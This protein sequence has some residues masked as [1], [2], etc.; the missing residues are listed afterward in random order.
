MKK[1]TLIPI[2]VGACLAFGICTNLTGFG[3]S[4]VTASVKDV[5][6]SD[7]NYLES[8][9]SRILPKKDCP[10]EKEVIE[11]SFT[12]ALIPA[13]IS[14]VYPETPKYDH[15]AEDK[16][17]TSP[18][19]D[20]KTTGVSANESQPKVQ[21][22]Q[23]EDVQIADLT[24]VPAEAE[25]AQDVYQEESSK[26]K[27]SGTAAEK[28]VKKESEDISSETKATKATKEKEE[29]TDTSAEKE[30]DL[31]DVHEHVLKPVYKTVHHDA[32]TH[33]ETKFVETGFESS[34]SRSVTYGDTTVSRG[35]YTV[36]RYED[37]SRVIET[38]KVYYYINGEEAGEEEYKAALEKIYAEAEANG[39]SDK[40]EERAVSGICATG[41]E[42][43]TEVVDSE[44]YDEE[45][46]DHY[47]C[48]HC[49]EIVDSI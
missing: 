43:E 3:G 18:V 20:D 8:V 32:V 41:E 46:L 37:N 1:R 5:V 31:A 48:E 12:C 33:T 9:I 45:V 6:S 19:S 47:E 22:S 26:A 34:G 36:G 38:R 29:N 21:P 23:E 11:P 16:E 44:A 7:N 2:G 25:Q 24:A 28:E 14:S 15:V 39:E 10:A 35:D 13:D 27:E 30:K 17:D 40:I 49:K 4:T 42:V